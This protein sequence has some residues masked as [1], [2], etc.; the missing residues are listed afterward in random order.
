LTI[1]AKGKYEF[2]I[3]AAI[4]GLSQREPPLPRDK[5]TKHH[6]TVA[7]NQGKKMAELEQENVVCTAIFQ[8]ARTT[9]DSG[10]RISFDLD[11]SQSEEVT[12]IAKMK[13][14]RLV[15]VVTLQDEESF[16]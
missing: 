12:R 16:D 9:T 3:D 1:A 15:L 4:V 14:R 11:E 10:W 6:K 8:G 5:K 7:V 2:S 13:N